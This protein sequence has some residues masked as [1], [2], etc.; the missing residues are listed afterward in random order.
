MDI[1]ERLECKARMKTVRMGLWKG[2]TLSSHNAVISPTLKV[3]ICTEYDLRVK[4][5]FLNG[6]LFFQKS[7]DVQLSKI[8]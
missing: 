2:L 4:V 5:S 6:F 3:D 8:T 7:L 1:F